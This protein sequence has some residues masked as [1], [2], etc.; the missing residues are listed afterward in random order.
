MNDSVFRSM[1]VRHAEQNKA[2]PSIAGAAYKAGDLIGSF[3]VNDV[4]GA[5]GFGVVYLVYSPDLKTV[6][7]LKTF[8]N[9]YLNDPPT[10]EQFRKEARIWVELE[11]HPFIVQAHFVDE[12]AGQLYIALE[13]IAPNSDGL[14]N[15]QEYLQKQPPDMRQSLRWAIQFCYGMEYAISKGIRC[16]RDIKPANILI[17]QDG[18]VKISDFGLAGVI[19]LMGA[20]IK[21]DGTGQDVNINVKSTTQ[22]AVFGTPSHM[23]PEQFADAASCDERSDIYSF[24]VVLY[25]MAAGGD[26]PFLPSNLIDHQPVWQL[27]RKLHEEAPVPELQT[28]LF[29]IIQRC[30]EKGPDDRYQTFAELHAELERL[31]M[32][33]TGEIVSVPQQD[34]INAFEW[35]NKGASLCVLGHF[36][37]AVTYLDKAIQLIPEDAGF[38]YNKGEC[39][40]MS[41]R[42]AEA[43]P[44][45]DEALKINPQRADAWHHAGLCLA[46]LVRHKEAIRY[47]DKALSLVPQAAEVWHAKGTSL[48]ELGRYE[49]AIKCFNETIRL[50][51]NLAL[52][53]YNKGNS[54]IALNRASEGIQCLTRATQL[55]PHDPFTWYNKAYNE[56]KLNR[57]SDATRS[58]RQFLSIAPAEH[59]SQIETARE[60]LRVNV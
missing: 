32:Q 15:L 60:Y 49:E 5:G 27:M 6:Y 22:G 21:A 24:G 43:I 34:E 16:H 39:Y 41:D 44:A 12:I 37:E 4:L 54:L 9:E 48:F 40:R 13:Y 57:R 20:K 30:L 38:W 50:T 31:L 47:F 46:D 29:P 56:A 17:G 2:S 7:A 59:I 26:L 18:A 58:F 33:E 36:N 42:Y 28:T 11:R 23:P 14:N 8:R 55:N 10:R 52:A 35:S 1:S 53:W 45:Y 3:Q 51:P 25:Q 19:E